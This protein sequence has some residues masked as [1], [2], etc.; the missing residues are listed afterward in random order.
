LQHA[1]FIIFSPNITTNPLLVNGTVTIAN[2]NDKQAIV[3][4]QDLIFQKRVELIRARLK[5]SMPE[6]DDQRDY[7][8]TLFFST[9]NFCK[10][11]NGVWTNYLI[12]A[13]MENFASSASENFRCPFKANE[14]YLLKDMIISSNFM[15]PF[16]S[17][18]KFRFECTVTGVVKGR[19]NAEMIYYLEFSGQIK[20]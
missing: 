16:M 14:R 6:Q 3:Y 18:M 13:F 1:Y 9:V 20:N 5:L 11:I 7:K 12:K 8:K 19:K 17:E 4:N 10:V 15:P 2:S